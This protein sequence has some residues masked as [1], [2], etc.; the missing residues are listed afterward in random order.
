MDVGLIPA[1]KLLAVMAVLSVKGTKGSFCF[2]VPSEN[3]L[4]FQIAL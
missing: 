4:V 1:G 2:H 3:E